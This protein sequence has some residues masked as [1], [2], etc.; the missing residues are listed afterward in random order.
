MT[1]EVGV[2]GKSIQYLNIHREGT[3]DQRFCSVD[4]LWTGPIL[5]KQSDYLVAISRFE[6]PLNRMPITRAVPNT[7]E[8][9]RYYDAALIPQ[10][11]DSAEANNGDPHKIS[12]AAY[13]T[14]RRAIVAK[15]EA[16]AQGEKSCV[17]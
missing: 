14:S 5:Q 3:K 6:V 15:V 7:V 17:E 4:E 12:C 16:D 1:T 11:N 9:F 8:I 2:P 10:I 13:A